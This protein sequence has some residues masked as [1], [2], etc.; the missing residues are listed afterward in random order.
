MLQRIGCGILWV[1][2][3]VTYI[4]TDHILDGLSDHESW[5]SF[6]AAAPGVVPTTLF[7]RVVLTTLSV[8]IFLLFH[9]HSPSLYVFLIAFI[10][11]VGLI[12]AQVQQ[13]GESAVILDLSELL[14]NGT[15][16]IITATHLADWAMTLCYA[17][18]SY[19]SFF[20][21]RR[22]YPYDYGKYVPPFPR[23]IV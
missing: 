15:E 18:V 3:I 20:A 12:L 9:F 5:L 21:Q 4:L 10:I 8:L 11:H 7:L 6:L 16:C 17:I 13:V 23:T 1:G 22:T 14:N 19:L 2:S